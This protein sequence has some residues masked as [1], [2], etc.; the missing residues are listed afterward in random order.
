MVEEIIELN[1]QLKGGWISVFSLAN[2]YRSAWLDVSDIQNMS[3]SMSR[4]MDISD[5]GLVLLSNYVKL[6]I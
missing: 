6:N 2:V 5:T 4:D 3:V 1:N